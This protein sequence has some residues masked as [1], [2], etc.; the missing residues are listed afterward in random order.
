MSNQQK[1]Q[2][3][4]DEDKATKEQDALAS[5]TPSVAGAE[6]V[7]AIDASA[8]DVQ[9][10]SDKSGEADKTDQA[11]KTPVSDD[12]VTARS[13]D[14]IGEQTLQTHAAPSPSNAGGSHAYSDSL[15]VTPFAGLPPTT[16]ETPSSVL[17]NAEPDAFA[18]SFF[19][20]SSAVQSSMR[21]ISPW[22]Q[23]LHGTAGHDVLV[24]SEGNDAV[25]GGS[26]DDIIFGGPGNDL[27]NGEAGNDTIYATNIWFD[28]DWS[29]R[30]TITIDSDLVS[31][32][33]SDFAVLIDGSGF[34]AE[35]WDTVSPDGSDIVISRP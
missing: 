9:L 33:L 27:L 7:A 10:A 24:G 13:E 20:E 31:H 34:G 4:G 19:G 25:Y 1:S 23:V 17:G 30:Q 3:R 11:A 32:D 15:D 18:Q 14:W 29:H 22:A 6:A 26:G 21:E 35:F 12:G 16:I 5:A 2:A 28:G 8:T